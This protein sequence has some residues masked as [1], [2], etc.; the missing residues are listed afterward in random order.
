MLCSPKLVNVINPGADA[1]RG[2]GGHAAL[3][4]AHFA[5]AQSEVDFFHLAVLELGGKRLMRAIGPG[6]NQNA[7]GIAVNAM[8]NAGSSIA[9]DSG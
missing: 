8:N 6:H 3:R 7:A 1:G 5:V 2:S 4:L 9:V